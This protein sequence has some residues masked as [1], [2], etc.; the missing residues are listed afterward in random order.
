VSAAGVSASFDGAAWQVVEAAGWHMTGYLFVSN[1]ATYVGSG[2]V[3]AIT[4]WKGDNV[5]EFYTDEHGIL[6]E[7]GLYLQYAD[8]PNNAS[9]VIDLRKRTWDGTFGLFAAEGGSIGRMPATASVA[10]GHPVRFFNR[11]RGGYERWTFTPYDLQLTV[12]GPLAPAQVT[13][14]LTRIQVAWNTSPLAGRDE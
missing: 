6:S 2:E 7:T 11:V 13:A 12:D 4:D 8:N 1:P 14:Q 5:T 3:V 10:A 9:G